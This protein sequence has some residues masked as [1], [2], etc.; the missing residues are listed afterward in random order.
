MD[1]LKIVF[2]TDFSDSA[3]NAIQYGIN[4]SNELVGDQVEA[5][6][7]HAYQPFVPVDSVSAIPVMENSALEEVSKDKLSTITK[8]QE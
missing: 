7:V 1:R 2:T 6:V 5:F 4:F 3:Y 8:I